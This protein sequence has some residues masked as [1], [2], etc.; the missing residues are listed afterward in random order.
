MAWSPEF[1][2]GVGWRLMLV[3]A[4]I[5]PSLERRLYPDHRLSNDIPI[6]PGGDDQYPT[7]ALVDQ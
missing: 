1:W 7:L 3:G 4:S 5:V 2:V 6:E